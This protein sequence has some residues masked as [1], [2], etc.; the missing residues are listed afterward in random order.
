MYFLSL[1]KFLVVCIW[2]IFVDNIGKLSLIII[3]SSFMLVAKQFKPVKV[4][5]V[6]FSQT[7]SNTGK[8]LYIEQYNSE[9]DIKF[10]LHVF[11]KPAKIKNGVFFIEETH[12]AKFIL[13]FFSVIILIVLLCIS[14]FSD[15][16]WEFSDGIEDSMKSLVYCEIEDSKYYYMALGRLLI[17]SDHIIKPY[18]ITYEIGLRSI[19]DI[20]R[21][22]KFK[23]KSANRD[24]LLDKL[25]IK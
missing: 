15:S 11:D 21:C 1:F 22:P 9:N 13:I 20:Y 7:K 23:T 17:R 19:F 5:S 10:K 16:E 4:P 6:V 14:L 18:N 3:M 25:G 24:G 12:P 2:N 8:Y